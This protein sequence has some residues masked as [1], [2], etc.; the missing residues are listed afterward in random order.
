MALGFGHNKALALQ[1]IK[2]FS[3]I[4][5][6]FRPTQGL[7]FARIAGSVFYKG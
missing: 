2:Q 1:T 3:T 4:N 6:L 7:L 5:V